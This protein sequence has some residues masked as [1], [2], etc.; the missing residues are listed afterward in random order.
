MGHHAGDRGNNHGFRAT[1]KTWEMFLSHLATMSAIE[2]SK[3]PGMPSAPAFGKKRKRDPGFHAR[4]T[5]I[6]STRRPGNKGHIYPPEI[7]E[8]CI[9]SV[10][11]I[12]I[13]RTS[14][15][16]E[17]PSFAGIYMKFWRDHEFRKRIIS[18][19]PKT[20]QALGEQLQ[21]QLR[22]NAIYR[23]VREAIPAHLDPVARDDIAQDMVL[24]VLEGD[25]TLTDLR[26]RAQEFVRQHWKLFGT[27]RLI[28]L[29]APIAAGSK[30]TFGDRLSTEAGAFWP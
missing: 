8:A 20:R 21:S 25:L 19:R 5:E 27:R 9:A 7:W 18:V 1:D 4:A 22:D 6:M 16:P 24:A 10:A 15:L 26:A 17:M 11:K 2:V 30:T 14:L 28:S 29:D 13:A 23:T 12:G 3:L